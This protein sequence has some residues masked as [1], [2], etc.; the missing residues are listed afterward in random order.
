MKPLNGKL[1]NDACTHASGQEAVVS[2]EQLDGFFQDFNEKAAQ[3]LDKELHYTELCKLLVDYRAA[4]ETVYGMSDRSELQVILRDRG[5]SLG[6]WEPQESGVQPF[7]AARSLHS[8]IAIMDHYIDTGDLDTE[9][10]H[11]LI[12]RA[13][14][15]G[16]CFRFD[17]LSGG[18]GLALK[19]EHDGS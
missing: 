16:L 8:Y 2:Y 5:A 19:E 9:K 18:Y 10:L 3:Y 7:D 4:L 11:A 17:K 1:I 15:H 13:R 6:L 14:E 12:A